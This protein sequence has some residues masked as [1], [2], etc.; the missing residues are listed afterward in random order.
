MLDERLAPKPTLATW[1]DLVLRVTYVSDEDVAS[2][3]I[4]LDVRDYKDQR[5]LVL[6]SGL[7]VP[8]VRGQHS[9]DC[10]IRRFPLAS[11]QFTLAA[12]LALSNSQ[13]LWRETGLA[14]FDVLARDVHGIGRA[15]VTSRML[16]AA[17]HDWAQAGAK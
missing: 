12:G 17:E 16:V 5:L 15:P 14:T 9:V 1:D 11:G 8:L 4:V 7:K 6:D 3:S 13:W 2:G 10:R